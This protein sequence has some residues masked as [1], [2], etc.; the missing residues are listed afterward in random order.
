MLKGRT[1]RHRLH[2]PPSLYHRRFLYLW[3]GL[4]IS[5]AGTQMQLWALFWHVR[6]LTPQPIALGGIGLARILPV[7]IFSLLGGV[8]ADKFDRRK[9]YFLAEVVLTL[10]AATLAW[11][12][13]RQWISLWHIYLLTAIQATA[14]AF[15]GPAR[16][17]L[18]P[19][20][21]SKDDLPNAFSMTSIAAQTGAILGPAISGWIIAYLG[22]AYPYFFNALSYLAV[23]L[24]LV[25]IGPVPQQIVNNHG[26]IFDGDAIREGL[27]FIFSQPLIFGSML[28]DFFATF[29]SSANTLMPIVARDVLHV[30]EIEYGWLS[31]GQA[32]GAVL[33]ALFVSQRKVIRHQGPVFLI[34][35]VVFG[36][37]TIIFGTARV[38][39]LAM[40]ALILIGAADAISTIIR[41]TIRQLL[42]PDYLRGRMTSVNQIFFIGGPQL[43]E[44]EAGLVAQF[45]GVPIAIISGGVGCIVAVAWIVRRLPQLW[46]YDGV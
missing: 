19:N 10:V 45:F 42:T 26:S 34:S 39:W 21:V 11:L 32:V 44:V 43:G 4:L 28:L 24:A 22:L 33:A 23:L 14:S 41:N 36:F 8:A 27:K 18:V 2:I 1:L 17:S 29:F 25:M 9:I 30:G 37:A 16:Q 20:L 15:D 12:T 5:T 7:I 31:S 13:Y 3:I 40:I 46:H 35:V 38:L 6:T